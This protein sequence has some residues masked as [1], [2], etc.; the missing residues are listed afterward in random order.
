MAEEERMKQK[1]EKKR[2]KKKVDGGRSGNLEGFQR[3]KEGSFVR[4]GK[5]SRRSVVD[6]LASGGL[7]GLRAQRWKVLWKPYGVVV[8]ESHYTAWVGICLFLTVRP[9]PGDSPVCLFTCKMRMT[10]NLPHWS[11]RD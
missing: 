4:T 10:Q 5:N 9:L 11:C 8:L 6:P 1:A 3:G 7:R 2:L